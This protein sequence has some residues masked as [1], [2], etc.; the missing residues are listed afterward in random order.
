MIILLL[1]CQ[2]VNVLK[3]SFL[4]STCSY[5]YVE[6]VW[7]V[8]TCERDQLSETDYIG[9][10][11]FAHNKRK[12]KQWKAKRGQYNSIR[13]QV[14]LIMMTMTANNESD[15]RR[16]EKW[17][18]S[19]LYGGVCGRLVRWNEIFTYS[20]WWFFFLSYELNTL[21]CGWWWMVTVNF[22]I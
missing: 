16:R 8:Y 22:N 18:S 15:Y 14:I 9:K 5:R 10:F 3:R 7:F 20:W 21:Q 2:E 4:T 11:P 13:S 12:I 17:N 6:T 1:L 19:L